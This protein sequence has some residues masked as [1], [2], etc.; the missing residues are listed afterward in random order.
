MQNPKSLRTKKLKKL[1]TVLIWIG[2]ICT[3]LGGK[4]LAGSTIYYGGTIIT[5]EGANHTVEAVLTRDGRIQSVGTKTD[6]SAGADPDTRMVDLEGMA[7]MPGFI[8]PHSHFPNNGYNDLFY[9]DL[10]SPPIGKINTLDELI[11][12]LTQKGKSLQKG[13]WIKGFGYDDTLLAEKRHPSKADL[14]RVAGNHPI[15][16]EHISGHMGVANSKA[17]RSANITGTTKA[18]PGG[19][20]ILGPDG[21]PTGLL[22]ESAMGLIAG[23]IPALTEAQKIEG[24]GRASEIYLQAGV[25]TAQDGA[26]IPTL[27]PDKPGDVPLFKLAI[28]Q[29]VLKNRVVVLPYVGIYSG[30]DFAPLWGSDH[31]AGT[32]LSG[33]TRMIT[34]GAG[35]LI[36]DGSIQGYTGYLS[37]PYYVQPEGKKDW[38]AYPWFSSADLSKRVKAL[39]DAGWQVAVHGNGDQAIEDIINA[40]ELAQQGSRRTDF[41]P[42]II[43]CQM[44]R[45]DQLDRVAALGIIPSFFVSHTY[46]WG[47]RHRE[48]FIGPERAL[49]IDPCKSALKRSI[50]FTHHNDTPVTPIS[51]LL[52]V[53]SAVNRISSNGNLIS[54]NDP[55]SDQRIDVYNALKGVTIDAAY[56]GFEESF[57]GSIKDGKLADFVVLDKNP[58]AVNPGTIKDIKI[59]ATIVN[60]Q[61]VYASEA[62]KAGKKGRVSSALSEQ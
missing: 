4:V 22:K 46:Y 24:I 17:L 11:A 48:I 34:L 7:L 41:R 27:G 6:I 45:E 14:D 43:H 57:K 26:A 12:A 49:R 42:I 55:G 37:K 60:D 16:I 38:A 32:D 52:S 3:M 35:K 40:I 30:I 23:V 31:T 15:Y 58:L 8:D 53:W 51:P 62:F 50:R 10:N 21:E 33:G 18:P 36:G 28:K 25:T 5:M 29:G 54:G 56:Q 61:I 13:A 19:E 20:I 9:A 39:Y 44:I 2:F 1:V 47:D 59:M